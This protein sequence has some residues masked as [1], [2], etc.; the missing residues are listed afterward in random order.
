VYC[1]AGLARFRVAQGDP[2]EAR[3]YADEAL[4][5]ARTIGDRRALARS[6]IGSAEALAALAE[7][8][9]ARKRLGEAV[10]SLNDTA[11]APELIDAL[12]VAV[13]WLLAE[14]HP[15]ADEIVRMALTHPAAW[16][17]TR[18][19]ART[20]GGKG[21]GRASTGHLGEPLLPGDLGG[22]AAS[23]IRPEWVASGPAASDALTAREREVADLIAR[24][25]SNREIADRLVISHETARVHVKRI[26]AKL[27]CASRA[28]VAV[29]VVTQGREDMTRPK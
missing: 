10:A 16:A 21:R 14:G 24:G 22:L 25:L 6:L 4:I 20:L 15:R 11:A 12:V 7:T 1:L 8:D 17:A 13:P 27:G 18:E 26:L 29:W 19:R 9:L 2:H 3:A 28:Q 23:L 5:I